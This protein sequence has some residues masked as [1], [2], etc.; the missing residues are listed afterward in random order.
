M[1]KR[2]SRA[3]LT[4]CMAL[5]TPAAPVLAQT[6]ASGKPTAEQDRNA[7]VQ[8]LEARLEG[9]HPGD[10]LYGPPA[11]RQPPDA[12]VQAIP[13]TAEN[14]V[15]TA[16]A[17]A[18]GKKMWERKFKD[19]RTMANCFPNGGKRVAATYPQYDAKAK[20]VVTQEIAISRC[21]R[22]HDEAELEP[23]YRGPALAYFRS[24]ADGEKIAVRVKGDGAQEKFSQGKALF[25][26]RMGQQNL[27]CASCHVRLAG[28]SY[29][30]L[31]I[32]PAVAQAASWPRLEPGGA[33]KTLQMQYKTCLA[34]MGATDIEPG[35]EEMNNLE[36]FH[37]FL[38]NGLGI[39]RLAGTAPRTDP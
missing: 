39:A 23:S 10:W 27:A 17:L 4:L 18:I 5:V 25:Q 20:I 15:N 34:R 31:P 2:F 16:D 33:I 38:S 1:L 30:R 21:L 12:N 6:T 19:G 9:T 7:I 29:R 24:L 3:W 11:P 26:R 22:L 36:Y 32:S 8:F 35:S 28:E 37:T 13:F 14:E